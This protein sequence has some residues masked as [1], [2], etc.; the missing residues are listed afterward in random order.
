MPFR[1]KVT[2]AYVSDNGDKSTIWRD[3]TGRGRERIKKQL[4]PDLEKRPVTL[5]YLRRFL[6]ELK[7]IRGRVIAAILLMP[8]TA[9]G[10]ALW[11]VA[12][13]LLV[14]GVVPVARG[15]L[16]T[17]AGGPS[18]LP[19]F[20]ARFFTPGSSAVIWAFLIAFV[21]SFT[22]VALL[23]FLMRYLM[24]LCG[25][26]LVARMRHKVHDH[27]QF[28]SVRYIEDTQVG[29]I[30]SR[31]IGDVQAVRNL[32]FGGFLEFARSLGVMIVLLGFL[33]YLDWWMTLVSIALVP[34]FALVFMRCRRRLRPAWRHIR[35][36]MALLTARIAE[37][38][39]GAKVVKTFV[40]ERHEN[41]GFF[42]WLNDLLRK[43]MRVHRIHMGM[44]A[45]ADWIAHIGRILVLAVGSWRVV[46]GELTFG[47]VF[48]FATAL[49]MFFQPMI[50]AVSINTQM[51]RAMA[52][53]ERIY[54]VLDLRPEV[55]EAPG[56]LRVGRLEGDVVFENV[57]FRYD[58]KNPEKVIRG[59]SFHARP[60]ECV[61]IVGPSGAGKTTLTNLLARFY[62][63]EKGRILVDG[64]DIR[65]LELAPFRRNLAVVLQ[66]TWL[67]NGTIRENI[68]YAV[69]GATDE[70]VRRAAE[71]ANALE[72]VERLPKGF[73]ERVGERGVKL[74]GGQKQRIAIARAI[75]AD[76]RIL[77]LD[78]A[79]SSLDSRA[80]ALIQEAL[81]RLMKGRT[82]LVI[83]HRLSTITN[84]DRILVL[85]EGRVVETGTHLELL[86]A[87]GDYYRMFMEQY[88]RVKFLHRAVE[89]YATHLVED[90]G[91]STARREA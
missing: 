58:E 56:A 57:S 15:D 19:A 53:L 14:D 18:K 25:E 33:L 23:A 26:W 34:G 37:V 1:A 35:E 40:K 29:G 24:L 50:Q 9:A 79:T 73:D 76:P 66:D 47:D 74:S 88:G 90:H 60:D 36:E 86:A 52:S 38:F 89:R 5:P 72:F 20:L 83:A 8:V 28:L 32:L 51:Q 2:H 71:Q 43:A 22:V 82:T 77:I 4:I 13:K 39:G 21:V 64:H 78:E 10:L 44:H 69:P 63:V 87:H 61:A 42:K 59:V 49:G 68:A 65:D 80:E 67:F 85:E 30:I 3:S 70:E 48:F 62:D 6:R 7:P 75:L 91:Y 12:T 31:V 46:R 11:P 17:L 84:A 16:S 55:R 41:T 45:G 54:D 81:E 27:I